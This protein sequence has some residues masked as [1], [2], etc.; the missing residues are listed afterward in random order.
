M[1]TLFLFVVLIMFM[2]FPLSINAGEEELEPGQ[3]EIRIESDK[4]TFT[5]PASATGPCN[6]LIRGYYWEEYDR[7]DIDG[8]VTRRGVEN[9]DVFLVGTPKHPYGE[10]N[11]TVYVVKNN[12]PKQEKPKEEKQEKPP[13]KEKSKPKEEK[14]EKNN[15]ESD[16]KQSSSNINEST[17]NNKNVGQNKTSNNTDSN[18]TETTNTPPSSSE[19]NIVE[20]DKTKKE[21]NSNEKNKDKNQIENELDSDIEQEQSIDEIEMPETTIEDILEIDKQSKEVND[22]S[23]QDSYIKN[24]SKNPEFI[25]HI[26][27]VSIFLG[28]LITITVTVLAYWLYRKGKIAR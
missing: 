7:F 27:L 1:R 11:L 24:E 4:H 16:E 9:G 22:L 5:N 15:V 10:S 2:A 12:P 6:G 3:C 21:D 18:S 14:Q 17:N 25:R 28:A 8:P 26:K 19:N 23:M 20:S 13:K